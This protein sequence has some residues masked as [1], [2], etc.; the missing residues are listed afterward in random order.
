MI[1]L[2]KKIDVDIISPDYSLVNEEL[3]KKSIIEKEAK[4]RQEKSHFAQGVAKEMLNRNL[5]DSELEDYLD[6]NISITD[7]MYDRGLMNGT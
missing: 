1:E 7:F 3:V 2:A 6:S 4:K 5:N